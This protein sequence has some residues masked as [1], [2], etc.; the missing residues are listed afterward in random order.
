M[1]RLLLLALPLMVFTSCEKIM[2]KQ[3]NVQIDASNAVTTVALPDGEYKYFGN[4]TKEELKEAYVRELTERLNSGKIHVVE[5]N[6]DYIIRLELIEVIERV[7]H[8]WY[9]D[10]DWALSSVAIRA[11]ATVNPVQVDIPRNMVWES[12][13]TEELDTDSKKGSKH[14]KDGKKGH[15]GVAIDGFG[16]M[17]GALRDNTKESRTRLK[18]YFKDRQ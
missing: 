4:L 14:A 13:S 16:G 5:S 3:T 15:G 10:T 8:E 1:K 17:E 7:E 2:L 9:D 12:E 11:T 6:P 18:K